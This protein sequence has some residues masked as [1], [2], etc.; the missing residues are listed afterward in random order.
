MR[1]PG[2]GGPGWAEI[3]VGGLPIDLLGR[4]F[5]GFGDADGSGQTGQMEIALEHLL[6]P[7][8]Q[9]GH[10]RGGGDDL[11]VSENESDIVW[12][13]RLPAMQSDEYVAGN[14]ADL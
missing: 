13:D 9:E 11:R 4:G 7:H 1:Q 14:E 3:E 12:F 8:H 6:I 10:L 5:R 2:R